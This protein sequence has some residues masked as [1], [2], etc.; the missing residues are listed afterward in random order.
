MPRRK[1]KSIDGQ[2]WQQF[3]QALVAR[4]EKRPTGPGWMTYAELQKKYPQMGDK[5]LRRALRG[6]ERFVGN[7]FNGTRLVQQHW[8][9]AK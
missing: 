6:A 3:E 8:Y 9:R 5:N 7:I 4:E 2:F 1:S